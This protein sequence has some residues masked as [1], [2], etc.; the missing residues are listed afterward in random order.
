MNK[1]RLIK[2][3]NLQSGHENGRSIP[4]LIQQNRSKSINYD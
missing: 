3:L 4:N 2:M 1:L